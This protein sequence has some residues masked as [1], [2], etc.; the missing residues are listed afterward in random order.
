VP[1]GD[2]FKFRNAEVQFQNMDQLVLLHQRQQPPRSAC[3][4]RYSNVEDYFDD[5]HARR[6]RLARV[7]V[8]LYTGDFLPYADN[9]DAYW[10]G[11]FT[12]RSHLKAATRAAESLVR[13]ADS[14]LALARAYSGNAAADTTWHT[15]LNAVEQARRDCALVQHHDGITGTSRHHVVDDYEFRLS[16][17]RSAARSALAASADALLRKPATAASK[18]QPLAAVRVGSEE[19]DRVFAC[20]GDAHALVLHNSLGWQRDSLIEVLVS[21]SKPCVVVGADGTS[22]LQEFAPAWNLNADVDVGAVADRFRLVFVATLAPLSFATVFLV[23]PSEPVVPPKGVCVS[24]LVAESADA[25]LENDQLAVSL[26]N[27]SLLQTL[28]SKRHGLRVGLNQQLHNYESSGSGAYIFRT[29]SPNPTRITPGPHHG[30]C[31][32]R[33]AVLQ[34]AAVRFSAMLRFTVQLVRTGDTES[35]LGSLLTVNYD[36]ISSDNGELMSRLQTDLDTNGRFST[37]NGLE[38]IDRQAHSDNKPEHHFFPAIG[39]AELVERSATGGIDQGDMRHLAQVNARPLSMTSLGSG[40]L[41][42]ALHRVLTNDDGRGLAQ[43]MRDPTKSRAQTQLIFGPSQFVAAQFRRAILLANNPTRLLASRHAFGAPADWLAHHRAHYSAFTTPLPDSVHLLSLRPRSI[44]SNDVVVRLLNADEF[45]VDDPLPSVEIDHL[46]ARHHVS[47]VRRV[48]LTLA[49]DAASA[50]HKAMNCDA[51]RVAPSYMD[52]ALRWQVMGEGK[53]ANVSQNTR[54]AGVFLSDSALARIKQDAGAGQD[55]G[56]RGLAR[57]LLSLDDCADCVFSVRPLEIATFVMQLEPTADTGAE[58]MPPRQRRLADL[59]PVEVPGE[60]ILAQV[61][62]IEPSKRPLVTAEMYAIGAPRASPP[63]RGAHEQQL[64]ERASLVHPLMVFTPV[65]LLMPVRP[66]AGALVEPWSVSVHLSDVKGCDS[67][68]WTID[69][70]PA[71]AS[72]FVLGGVDSNGTPLALGSIVEG[73]MEVRL[74]DIVAIAQCGD[75]KVS[76][77]AVVRIVSQAGLAAVEL[78]ALQARQL[79]EAATKTIHTTANASLFAVIDESTTRWLEVTSFVIFVVSGVVILIALALIERSGRR[80]L[81]RRTGGGG[82]GGGGGGG[83]GNV[84]SG[85]RMMS[86][87]TLLPTTTNQ[88]KQK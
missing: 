61:A 28:Y 63:K 5:V 68:E 8:P 31:M 50:T 76:T 48:T 44:S 30:I 32:H 7:T 57:R 41:E 62:P 46:F 3:S 54:E 43:G 42:S 24:S 52:P 34:E 55:A 84:G 60:A 67:C 4:V 77:T 1:F 20:S 73:G 72:N 11:Y 83:S 71:K 49:D 85:S 9:G 17:A 74:V 78:K 13:N 79:R 69:G 39:G 15:I 2:D 87:S 45:G 21:S 23:E 59:R 53:A 14:A 80:A 56:A 88:N 19:P 27:D 25:V 35:L 82:S 38:L 16:N 75:D 26:T 18:A 47:D 29:S 6:R 66:I 22:L 51:L 36:A 58:V 12:S 70:K 33:G 40:Q 86:S 10:T 65:G 81:Q 37:D 64:S